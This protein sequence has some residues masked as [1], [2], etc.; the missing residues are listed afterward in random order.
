[1]ELG[2]FLYQYFGPFRGP[3]ESR[4]DRHIGVKPNT[5]VAPVAGRDHPSIKVKDAL[6]LGTVK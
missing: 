6:Q 4:E 5:I 2:A 3:S 1:M